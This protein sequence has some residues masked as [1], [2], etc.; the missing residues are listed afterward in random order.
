MAPLDRCLASM[1]GLTLRASRPLA[2]QTI[3]RYLA[4]ALVQVR[5]ASVIRSKKEKKKKPLS[6]EYKRHK[7]SKYPDHKQ[8]SLLEAMRILRASEVGQ[9]GASVK[10]ELH[11]TFKTIRSGPVVRSSVRL[12]YPVNTDWSVAVICPEG[13]DIANAALAAGAV[14]VGEETLFEKIRKEEIN[15]DRLICHEKSEKA[16]NKAALGRILGPKGLMPSQ[17]MKTIV[18]DVSKSIKDLAGAADYR[19]RSGVI[20]LAIGQLGYTPDQLKANISTL[21]KKIKAEAAEIAE[22]SLKEVH[23]VVLSTTMGPALSLSGKLSDE[24][25]TVKAEDVSTVM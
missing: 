13:S 9:P 11:I 5:N 14:A 23:E 20:H 16:L 6:K 15:F 8:Y 17:R 25:T 19:E 24:T 18:S 1:A 7:L 22:D 12:P 2:N 21:M 3:P 4:P 10:Y